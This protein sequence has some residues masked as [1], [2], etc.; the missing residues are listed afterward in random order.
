MTPWTTE[1]TMSIEDL[2]KAFAWDVKDEAM[3]LKNHGVDN[4]EG[5]QLA[6][7]SKKLNAQSRDANALSKSANAMAGQRKDGTWDSSKA[8]IYTGASKQVGDAQVRSSQAKLIWMPPMLTMS[9]RR[10]LTMLACVTLPMEG[11]HDTSSPREH[12]SKAGEHVQKA[13]SDLRSAGHHLDDAGDHKGATAARAKANSAS[14]EWK[15]D[16]DGKF[17]GGKTE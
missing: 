13:V 1:M 12:M 17:T 7:I 14:D 4:E 2:F 3:E 9:I 11:R 15:R 8:P 10:K 5:N 6:H 16:K